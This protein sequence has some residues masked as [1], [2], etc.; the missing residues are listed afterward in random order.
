MSV[1]A[2]MLILA[3]EARGLTQKELAAELLVQQGTVSKMEAGLLSP[4]EE[5]LRKYS[6]VLQFP[7]DFFSQSD[8]VFGFNSTVFFHRKRQALS[9]KV[10][11]RLHAFM[12]LTRMRITRMLRSATISVAQ[13][14]SRLEL[15]EF[16]GGPSE[17]ARLARSMWMVPHGP[18]SSVT[19]IIENAGG[20]VVRFDFGTKQIDAI[21]EWVPGYPPIF[22]VNSDSGITGD[23]LRLTLS[24]EI[25][26]MLMHRFPSPEMEDEANEFAAEF[27]MPRG[28][29]KASL[30]NLTLVKLTQLK[31]I[32]KVSMAALI[33]RAYDLKTITETQRRYMFMN[34]SKKGYRTREPEETDVPIERP[35]LLT[36]LALEHLRELG[37]SV[38]EMMGLLFYTDENEF[39]SVY[40]GSDSLRLVS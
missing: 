32:W 40:M 2:E 9:D 36:R 1:N 3:R 4:P 25:G 39:R 35:E 19:E 34:L 30:Y 38:R 6:G 27:L 31:R 17:I 24:H 29:I 16:K 11:R 10:L 33:Q 15:S 22:L 7:I 14:F 37:F 21:S 20:I 26:H 28:E 8:R 12:N 23:R 18:I 13:G 5:T